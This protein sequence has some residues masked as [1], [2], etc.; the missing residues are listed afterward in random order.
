MA[1]DVS[2]LTNYTKENEAQLTTRSL[3]GAKTLKIVYAEGTVMTGVKSSEKI[4]EMSTDAIF[5]NGGACGFTSSGNTVFTQRTVTVGKIKVNEALCPA[6]L[7]TKYTQKA[8]KAGSRNDSI[9]F[10]QEYSELKAGITSEQLEVAAWQGDTAH[11]NVNLNKFDGYIKLIDNS[12][13]AVNGNPTGITVATG[14]TVSNVK[15]I[16]NGVWAKLPARVQGKDD[17][18]IFCG[19]DIFVLFIQAYTDA[20]LFNFAPGGKEVAEASG[21]VIIPGTFYK[22]TAV[23]GLD[24]TNRLFALRTSNMYIGTDLENEEEKFE[25][26]FA[27]E[28]DE[29]R[30]VNVFKYGV[31]VAYPDEIVSFKLV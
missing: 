11:G 27:K 29:V 8:L 25:I 9:P 21:E 3:F 20:N 10:E 31:Q 15:A 19:W 17:V 28:A 18:R 30:Y 16:V 22:L 2:A 5:Q 24:G 13:A 6:T 23:H 4:N 26:F 7:E 12:A 1:Y 14:I